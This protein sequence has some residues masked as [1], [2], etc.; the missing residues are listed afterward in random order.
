MEVTPRGS[1]HTGAARAGSPVLDGDM[2]Q[3]LT[4]CTSGPQLFWHQGLIS[5]KT[6]FPWTGEGGW[7]Q[8]DSSITFIVHFISV[9]IIAA[10]LQIIRQ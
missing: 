8:N 9:I 7:F 3:V 6:I 5:W 10:P 1:Q 4:P 2:L